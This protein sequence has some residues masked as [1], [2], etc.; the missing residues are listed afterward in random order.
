MT[1]LNKKILS[2]SLIFFALSG[3]TAVLN[4]GF[5]PIM[6]RFANVATFGE[7][8]FFITLLNQFGVGFVVLNILS[9]IITAESK[10]K[11]K[12]TAELAGLGKLSSIIVAG[13]AVIGS[14]FLIISQNT[15]HIQ[16]IWSIFA[17]SLSLLV[18]IPYIIEIGRLQGE[19][20]FAFSGVVGIIASLSRIIFATIFV[21]MGWGAFGAMIG[22]TIGLI[23]AYLVSLLKN[24]RL[25]IKNHY[26]KHYLSDIKRILPRK[27]VI[28]TTLFSITAITVISTI[29]VFI[30]KSNLSSYMVGQYAGISTIAKVILA[31]MEPLTRLSI[32]AM[33]D[34]SKVLVRRYL[35]TLIGL[36]A[37]CVALILIFEDFII[38]VGFNSNGLML[39][40]YLPL[41]LLSI[42]IFSLLMFLCVVSICRHKLADAAI[43]GAL[44]IVGFIVFFYIFRGSPII[45]RTLISEVIVGGLALLWLGG[46]NLKYIFSSSAT[47]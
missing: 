32:P 35:Y 46:R 29:D 33:I 47:S 10:D 16:S 15:F 11:H 31:I 44:L 45:Y 1:K 25:E 14:A 28:L 39:K 9:I 22:Y 13:I 24:Q 26:F 38:R 7:I 2:G 42:A 4:Y 8:Q 30:A 23:I 37:V 18:N 40:G 27:Y 19:D 34:G 5:Y 3:V 36:I 12:Y 41:E 43:G 17:L 20:H 21:M 6:A